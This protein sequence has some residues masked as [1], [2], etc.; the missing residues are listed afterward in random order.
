MSMRPLDRLTSIRAKLG[1]VIVFAVAVTIVIMYVAVGFALHKLQTPERTTEAYGEASGVA[2]LG[3]TDLGRPS[4]ALLRAVSQI[5]NPVIVVDGSAQRLVGNMPIPPTVNK[6]LAGH[7]DRGRIGRQEYVGVPVIRSG[8]VVGAVY[9][10]Y[11]VEGGGILGAI[12][13]TESFVRK[14]W[15]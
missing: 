8:T 2:A 11:R 15:C 6:A 5:P 4:A 12:R 9:L 7:I 10:S 1:S 14:L 3:F 13:G